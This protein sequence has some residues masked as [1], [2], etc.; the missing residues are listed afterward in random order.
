MHKVWIPPGCVNFIWCYAL[1]YKT[2]KLNMQAFCLF[3]AQSRMSAA[4]LIP[5]HRDEVLNA[6]L[7]SQSLRPALVSLS[8]CLRLR[9]TE[10]KGAILVELKVNQCQ[11]R[12][13]CYGTLDL[14]LY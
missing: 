9:G 13:D 12:Q 11:S 14:R 2:H 4:H 3:V 1:C 6:E 5:I 10:T 8:Y 7:H